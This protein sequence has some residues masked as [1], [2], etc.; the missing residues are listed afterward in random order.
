MN[1][2]V[3]SCMSAA[4]RLAC[5]NTLICVASLMAT[6]YYVDGAS[7]TDVPN[8]GTQSQPWKSVDYAL[9]RIPVP[10][11]GRHR[12]L[13]RGNQTYV[14][15]STIT[16]R[17]GIDLVGDGA[18][19]PTFV[20]PSTGV[21]FRVDSAADADHGLRSLVVKQGSVAVQ[22]GSTSIQVFA[23]R[24]AIEDCSFEGQSKASLDLDSSGYF[25]S[26][27][28]VASC[29]FEN[30]PAGLR[31]TAESRPM[32]LTVG[33]C[34]FSQAPCAFVSRQ[35]YGLGVVTFNVAVEDCRFVGCK[36]AGLDVYTAS[37]SSRQELR[38]DVRRCAFRHN[39]IGMKASLAVDGRLAV[40][41]STFVGHDKAMQ[42]SSVGSLWQDV[43]QSF[44]FTH[45][46]IQRALGAGISFVSG[47]RV[48]AL[49]VYTRSNLISYCGI[50]VDVEI[51]A[52]ATGTVASHGDVVRNNI[53]AAMSVVGQSR[54]CPVTISNS[55][56]AGSHTGL[57]AGGTSPTHVEFS[58]IADCPA[59]PLNLG[60][61]S[62]T[63]DHCVLDNPYLPE[64]SGGA[65]LSVRYTCSRTTQFVG[66]GNMLAD[67]QLVRPYYKLGAGSPCIDAGD[68]AA[69]GTTDYEGHVRVFGPR[70]DLGA[71]EVLPGT[72]WRFGAPMPV[73]RNGFHPQ[74]GTSVGGVR[75]GQTMN[76][77]MFGGVDSAQN[78][79]LGAVLM[80][81]ASDGLQFEDIDAV[82]PGG[83]LYFTPIAFTS[84]LPVSNT[85]VCI[86][87]IQ[88]PM[89]NAL[90]GSTFA[91]QWLCLTPGSSALGAMVT[92]GLRFTIGQ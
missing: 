72:G 35:S 26:D 32:R 84:L 82:M 90:V 44:E 12:V 10:T 68:P 31:V 61:Q 60:S 53:V 88:I 77:V 29:D 8:G 80:L 55:I 14:L 13:I 37:M 45:N 75:I 17:R 3:T 51:G 67:P 62:V 47:S 79:S 66:T 23:L 33:G 18:I 6:D 89:Q 5:A 39:L 21:A 83:Q 25:P 24:L 34:N 59:Y 87:R 46:V 56:L 42:V 49:G 11:S 92:D 50:G 70:V 16:L 64:V 27:V 81:G 65:G 20:A 43:R 91:A 74:M 19:R 9:T 76:S 63:L 15:T 30:A 7:G 71:D 69:T 86:A 22:S 85:G 40:D 48:P 73:A 28:R 78:A 52:G 58:T 36:S 38:M 57:H 1:S 41:Q 54:T 2:R 4:L